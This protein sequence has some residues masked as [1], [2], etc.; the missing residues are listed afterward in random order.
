MNGKKMRNLYKILCIATIL[1]VAGCGGGGGSSGTSPGGGNGG[2][3]NVASFDYQVDKAALTNSGSDD[4]TLTIT[5]LDSKNNPVSDAAVS[6]T[7]DTGIY[8]PISSA[9]D[10]AGKA[11]GKISVGSNKS[12]RNIAYTMTVG[13]QKKSGVIAVTGSAIDVTTVPSAPRPGSAVTVSVKV[14]DV[15][16]TGIANTPVALSGTLGFSNSLTTDSN[17]TAT[18]RIAAA[19]SAAGIYS[20]EATGSGVV[21]RRDVQVVGDSGGVPDAVGVISAANLAI[22]PNTIAPNN[23]GAST[24]RATLRAVFQNAANQAIKNV[25]VRFEIV[26]PVLGSGER[27]STEDAVIYTNESGIATA[28]YISGT[29]SSPTNGVRIRACYGYTDADI[30]NGA[31]PQALVAS[32]TVASAPLSITLGENNELEKGANNLTYIKK[33][34]VAV[35][36]SAGN[37]ISGATISAS[38]DLRR[39]GKGSWSV[40]KGGEGKDDEYS[41]VVLW[42]A[43]E[44][45]N[46][47]GLLDTG[48][49]VD[50]DGQLKPR[51]ADI[52]IS[53]LGG[54]VTGTNGRATLQVEYPQNV[55]SWIDYAIKVTTTV[56]GSEGMFEKGYITDVAEADMKNGSFLTSPFGTSMSCTNPN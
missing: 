18:A 29:R 2:A 14:S 15:N 48:E 55:G 17:G 13:N 34:D 16:G 31:C 46:R 10:S 30:A 53:Y 6:V 19:P 56:A 22:T 37:A 49:D 41:R 23:S 38:V 11:A 1:S 3:Q 26:P 5:A 52:I 27:I 7:V 12:N 25:R 24:N 32:M 36:D 45:T 44:D 21:A 39:Y 50:G 51:K 9:T 8:T 35:A 20:V 54:Q 28:E 47:N 40:I 33:F 43:N 42:C 4:A